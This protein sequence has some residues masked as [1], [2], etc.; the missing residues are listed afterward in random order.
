MEGC[1]IHLLMGVIRPKMTAS[2]GFRVPGLFQ[3]KFMGRMAAVTPFLD[4]VTA[5]TEGGAD[6]LGNG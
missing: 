3:G 1:F 5:L 2:A 4:D 6:F